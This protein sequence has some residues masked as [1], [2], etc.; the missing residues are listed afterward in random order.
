MRHFGWRG[1]LIEPN[2]YLLPKIEKE[3]AGLD[4]KLAPVAAASYSGSATLHLGVHDEISS[5]HRKATEHWGP[6]HET[7]TVITE[8]LPAIL[9]AN[10]VPLAFGL[11][12][13]DAEGEGTNLLE[14]V[15]ASGYRPTWVIIEVVEG[16]KIASLDELRL[17]AELKAR[18]RIVARTRPNLILEY[19]E[20]TK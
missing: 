20:T 16:L 2:P 3:F 15:F 18:Y 7:C 17:S 19:V 5:I 4:Y 8:R 9:A 10:D 12:S 6:V 11:L 1:L 14:D 13:I